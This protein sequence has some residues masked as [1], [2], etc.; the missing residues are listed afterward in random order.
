M[1]VSIF[2]TRYVS[3]DSFILASGIFLIYVECLLFTTLTLI[4]IWFLIGYTYYVNA[5]IVI[6]HIYEHPVKHAT[7][8]ICIINSLLVHTI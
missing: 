8:Y 1:K 2:L 6:L 3:L 4:S 5:C 7:N